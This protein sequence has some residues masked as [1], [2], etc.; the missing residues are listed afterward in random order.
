MLTR[1]REIEEMSMNFLSMIV[2]II[3]KPDKNGLLH[4]ISE[5]SEYPFSSPKLDRPRN[6]TRP[7]SPGQSRS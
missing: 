7:G 4:Q 6:I 1:S 3:N 2:S 5:V